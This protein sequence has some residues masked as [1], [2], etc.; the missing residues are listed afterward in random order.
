MSDTEIMVIRWFPLFQALLQ[1]ICLQTSET[2]FSASGF[3]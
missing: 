1:G 3:L 2:S